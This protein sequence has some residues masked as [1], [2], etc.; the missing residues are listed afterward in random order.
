MDEPL[1]LPAVRALAHHHPFIEESHYALFPP[2]A[3][4]PSY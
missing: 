4:A 2:C 1:D 3:L